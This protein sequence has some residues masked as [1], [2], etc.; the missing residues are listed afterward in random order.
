MT[1]SNALAP[2][3]LVFIKDENNSFRGHMNQ[4]LDICFHLSSMC[5]FGIKYRDYTMGNALYDFYSFVEEYQKTH[6]FTMLTRSI[7]D[8]PQLV[9]KNR[10][11][12]FPWCNLFI[13]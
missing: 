12:H 2:K 3:T 8:T 7:S 6:S 10:T 11:K 9:N 4:N 1:G 13:L 5:S